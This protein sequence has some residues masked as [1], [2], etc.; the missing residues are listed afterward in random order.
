MA[1]RQRRRSDGVAVPGTRSRRRRLPKPGVRLLGVID[2]GSRALR[3]AVGEV[4]ADGS[5]R[6]LEALNAPVSLGLDTLSTRRIRFAT[7][8]AAVST[9]RDF[10]AVAASYGIEPREL[11]A[12]ATTAVRDARN[13]DVFLDRVEKACGLRIEVIEAIE[14]S[15]LLYQI[16]RHTVGPGFDQGTC[17]LLSLGAGGTQI[18]LQHEGEIVL[19]ETR[20][21]GLLRLWGSRPSERTAILSARRFLEKEV[22]ALQRL[23]DLSEVTLVYVVNQELFHL[24]R[25]MARAKPTDGGLRVAR[26]ELER[27]RSE[28]DRLSTDDLLQNLGL[29]YPT[30]EMGRMAFEELVTFSAATS[31]KAITA[32]DTTMLESLLL[33]SRLR[34]EGTP[35]VDLLAE[36]IESAAM[37]LGRKYHFDEAHAVHVRDLALQL[38]DSLLHMTHLPDRAR[39]LLSLAAILHDIGYFV[40]FHAHEQHSRYLISSSEIMGLSRGDL[41]RIAILARYHRGAA[42]E[43]FCPELSQVPAA[44]RVDLLKTAALLR[45]ADALDED[46]QQ[47]VHR[48]RVEPTPDVLRVYA[49]TRAGSREAFSSIAQAFKGKAD[50]FAEIF[51]VEPTVTEVLAT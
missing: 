37:A 15:R 27:I 19:G 10:L 11:R 30:A 50:L 22:R 29:D 5:V 47:R 12:V 8:E 21:F 35:R 4:L 32:L 18:I 23:H 16:A 38:F 36:Q 2:V 25:G 9:L 51:G 34:L 1:A 28:M 3:L 24:L 14:E 44:E 40:S 26:S 17:M 48:V 45:L 46:D 20:H 13:R 7:T 41:E 42:S 49:E 43:I 39:L 33:D 31:A 6:P